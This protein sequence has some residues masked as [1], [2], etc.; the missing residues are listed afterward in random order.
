[1]LDINIV[2]Y[3]HQEIALR[4]IGDK[5]WALDVSTGGQYRL[6]ETS[7]FIL[8]LFRTPQSIAGAT[9]RILKKYNVDKE[10]VMADCDKILQFAVEKNILKE[11]VS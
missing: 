2:L 9:E 1:M 6:N 10:R 7:Y 8:G 4:G 3:L 11:I 5:Y